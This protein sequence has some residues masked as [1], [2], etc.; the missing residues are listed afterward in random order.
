MR[1]SRRKIRILDI[2][3]YRMK[4]LLYAAAAACL[5]VCSCSKP[6]D[7]DSPAVTTKDVVTENGVVKVTPYE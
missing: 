7:D 6:A 2:N 1:L 4:N 5:L 3:R